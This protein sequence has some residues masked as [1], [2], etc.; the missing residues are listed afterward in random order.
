MNLTKEQSILLGTALAKPDLVLATAADSPNDVVWM[1]L[2]EKGVLQI[3]DAGALDRS[4]AEWIRIASR[5]DLRCYRVTERAV[6]AVA[7]VAVKL[8]RVT[9]ADIHQTAGTA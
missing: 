9:A 2:V 5:L 1:E 4:D 6:R 7:E 3:V 8:E